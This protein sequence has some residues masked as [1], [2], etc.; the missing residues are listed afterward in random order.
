MKRVLLLCLVFLLI[1]PSAFAEL[2]EITY[3]VP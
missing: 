2:V 1:F 3:L